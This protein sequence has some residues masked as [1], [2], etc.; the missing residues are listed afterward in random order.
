MLSYESQ[1][2]YHNLIANSSSGAQTR[3]EQHVEISH[4]NHA[5]GLVN[6]LLDLE[7]LIHFTSQL[8]TLET[9]FWSLICG[10]CSWRCIR[11]TNTKYDESMITTNIGQTQITQKPKKQH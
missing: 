4:P 11:N 7:L 1:Y 9:S 3:P 8:L 6:I 10:Y 2:H 5:S